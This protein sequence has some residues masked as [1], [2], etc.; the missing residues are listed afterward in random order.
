MEQ[1]DDYWLKHYK[2]KPCPVA[3]YLTASILPSRVNPWI[4]DL[5]AGIGSTILG[6]PIEFQ[7]EAY[8]LD[9]SIRAVATARSN[10]LNAH[11]GNLEFKQNPPRLFDIVIAS[12]ILGY[13]SPLSLMTNVKQFL[14][15]PDPNSLAIFTPPNA[16]CP[17]KPTVS[18]TY[19]DILEIVPSHGMEVIYADPATGV[20]TAR[21]RTSN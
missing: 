7:S 6:L 20:V 9:F 16:K 2:Q 13:V 1:W 12:R 14:S 18:V 21:I 4:A 15:R 11:F 3:K 17:V 5:G 10:G 19:E 8:L